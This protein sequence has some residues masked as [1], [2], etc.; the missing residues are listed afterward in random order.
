MGITE[1]EIEIDTREITGIVTEGITET[2]IEIDTRGITGIV[3]EI[4]TEMALTDI[5][6]G[7]VH[8]AGKD[9]NYLLIVKVFN[10]TCKY[11][12]RIVHTCD[13]DRW[14]I[15]LKNNLLNSK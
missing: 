12:I 10:C 3:T 5:E 4:I 8:T 2:E 13:Y 15:A 11:K 9:I 7:G 1:T 14:N 6:R